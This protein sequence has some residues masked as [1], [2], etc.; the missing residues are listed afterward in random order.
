MHYVYALECQGMPFSEVLA[1][2]RKVI[3]RK[4]QD[5]NQRFVKRSTWDCNETGWLV[6]WLVG[7]WLVHLQTACFEAFFPIFLGFLDRKT[8]RQSKERL[9]T[10][11]CCLVYRDFQA[12]PNCIQVALSILILLPP[13]SMKGPPQSDLWRVHVQLSVPCEW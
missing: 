3:S 1:S 7:G 2:Y 6:G 5:Y 4:M 11:E 8:N 10:E 12:Q 9:F 13:F